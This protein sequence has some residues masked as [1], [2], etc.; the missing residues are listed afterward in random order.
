MLEEKNEMINMEDTKRKILI[1]SF[2]VA[3]MLTLPLTTVAGDPSSI[4]DNERTEETDRIMSS[5]V[6]DPSALIMPYDII[7]FSTITQEQAIEMLE[8]A[9]EQL[10]SEYGDDP[11]TQQLIS[12][13]RVE[14]SSF[15]ENEEGT[16]EGESLLCVL[17]LFMIVRRIA[18]ILGITIEEVWMA[19]NGYMSPEAFLLDML[20]KI[21]H[22]AILVLLVT[23]YIVLCIDDEGGS[24]C[25]STL[26]SYNVLTIEDLQTV[27]I[28]VDCG[29]TGSEGSP[30]N[31]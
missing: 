9:L 13:I 22:S 8:M 20:R 30:T 4:L 2:F 5:S 3:L 21:R 23:A 12:M 27:M 25:A 7:D 16:L 17:L 11:E 14:L 6:V 28:Q 1:A 18:M 26:A 15:T 24:S 19:L 10:S 31:S 29:C